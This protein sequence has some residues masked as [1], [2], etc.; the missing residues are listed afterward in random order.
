MWA[1]T[2]CG[3]LPVGVSIAMCARF[4][5][6]PRLLSNM[7]WPLWCV[8]VLQEYF[9]EH[10]FIATR[11]YEVDFYCVWKFPCSLSIMCCV[12]TVEFVLCLKD[13]ESGNAACSYVHMDFFH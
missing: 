1:V 3:N 12:I 5:R 7:K 6:S 11:L 10:V 8:V 4:G 13:I 9:T 2:A